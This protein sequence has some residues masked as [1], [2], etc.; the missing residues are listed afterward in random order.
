MRLLITQ[1]ANLFLGQPSVHIR[2]QRTAARAVRLVHPMLPRTRNGIIVQQ[3]VTV[4]LQCFR[5]CVPHFSIHSSVRAC[6]AIFRSL[7]LFCLLL[8]YLLS[9]AQH[10]PASRSAR[11]RRHHVNAL[12]R[13]RTQ[14]LVLDGRNFLVLLLF[15][16][17]NHINITSRTTATWRLLIFLLVPIFNH[18]GLV[19]ALNHTLHHL[20]TILICS[21]FV[22][23]VSAVKSILSVF[24]LLLLSNPLVARLSFTRPRAI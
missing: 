8:L 23:D 12:L 9:R 2:I 22:V 6:L 1:P 17:H 21:R 16:I 7:L 24:V 4:G 13:C 18:G 19:I 15:L 20:L 11:R 10:T 14:R 3:I 5:S